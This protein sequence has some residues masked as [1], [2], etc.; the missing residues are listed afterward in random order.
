MTTK[1]KNI[2]FGNLITEEESQKYIGFI[3][4]ITINDQKYIG[5]KVFRYN[6]TKKIK[7]KKNKKHFT[8]ESDWKTYYGSS[9]YFEKLIENDPNCAK[10]E[11]IKLVE[12][13]VMYWE[14]YYQIKYDVLHDDLF[15]NEHICGRYYRNKV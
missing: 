14:M 2:T 1:N 7:D 10:Y 8:V 5:S 11:V 12:R 9:E 13:N 6:K 4:K 3:Y 15:V